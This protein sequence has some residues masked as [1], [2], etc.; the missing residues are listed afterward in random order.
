MEFI[1]P[2]NNELNDEENLLIL[3]QYINIYLENN[4]PGQATRMALSFPVWVWDDPAGEERLWFSGENEAL[5]QPPLYL[6][7]ITAIREEQI[8]NFT[9][10]MLQ[11]VEQ[12]EDMV[13]AVEA[14][15]NLQAWNSG[16]ELTGIACVNVY[17]YPAEPPPIN[18][19]NDVAYGADGILPTW[20]T[21][22]PSVYPMG[23]QRNS[24]GLCFFRCLSLAL[25]RAKNPQKC[26]DAAKKLVKES[27]IENQIREAGNSVGLNYA[28][29]N[30]MIH[31]MEGVFEVNINIFT[32]LNGV[33][34]QVRHSRKNENVVNL[35]AHVYEEQSSQVKRVHLSLIHDLEG[36]TKTFACTKCSRI[37]EKRP[38][39]KKHEEDCT[40]ESTLS[41]FPKDV[42]FV[43]PRGT[44][45]DFLQSN[46]S[47]ILNQLHEMM[48]DFV[49]LDD[50]TFFTRSE[51]F[52]FNNRSELQLELQK[53]QQLYENRWKHIH[54]LV[55]GKTQQSKISNLKRWS[56]R[57]VIVEYGSG[58][59]DWSDVQVIDHRGRFIETKDLLILDIEKMLSR[60]KKDEFL[61][62]QTLNDAI[63]EFH[64]H[65][66]KSHISIFHDVI[67]LPKALLH[68]MFNEIPPRTLSLPEN[69]VTYNLLKD[70]IIGGMGQ[71]N[72]HLVIGGRIESYD[73]T[74]MYAYALAQP[75]PCGLSKYKRLNQYEATDVIERIK[76]D[77]FIGFIRCNVITP[78]NL[79]HKYSDLPLVVNKGG[80][81]SYNGDHVVVWYRLARYYLKSGLTVIPFESLEYETTKPIFSSYVQRAV[82]ERIDADKTQNRP[83]IQI[84]KF[85]LSAAHGVLH[86]NKS[87]NPDVIVCDIDQ[88]YKH[89]ND[90]HFVSM[91]HINDHTVSIRKTKSQV[92]LDQPIQVA[93][94]IYAESK[95]HFFEFYYD[96][97]KPNFEFEPL[98]FQTDAV[99]LSLKKPT[100]LDCLH[101]E[102][103]V[104]DWLSLSDDT[105]RVPGLFHL[106]KEGCNFIATGINRYSVTCDELQPRSKPFKNR[107]RIINEDGITT[108]PFQPTYF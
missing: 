77:K 33:T 58:G 41:K 79:R 42:Y 16:V 82:S 108:S 96:F 23:G 92:V 62:G 99:I 30:E 14:L 24:D 4:Y 2:W 48:L 107:K 60:F 46:R 18:L 8:G 66:L 94:A 81:N 39:R 95:L 1:Y 86:M 63:R 90:K 36:F 44:L 56:R 28:V 68:I 84:Q 67:T 20:L 15:V 29:T 35:Y 32:N 59:Y 3:E 97:L 6:S 64:N 25:G 91:K 43:P 50:L 69:M 51:I 89:V 13:G 9:N 101:T 34:Y 54:S 21:S 47:D 85:K 38:D 55:L 71:I 102:I 98:L 104:D 83:L 10:E 74:S 88:S 61:N 93:A 40:G 37:F 22:T 53:Q 11:Y 80:L 27:G 73:C 100:L 12:N 76:S 70:G 57:M 75:M 31:H 17:I 26:T 87:C 72:R 5:P 103:D 65:F 105:K 7:R 106:E 49:V 45:F 19:P 78:D 52:T